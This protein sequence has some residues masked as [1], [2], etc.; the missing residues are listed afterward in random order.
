MQV[1]GANLECDGVE[2][3]R[4]SV[5]TYEDALEAA[6]RARWPEARVTIDT[7]WDASGARRDDEV[8]CDDWRE[9]R[10]ALDELTEIANKT[11]MAWVME[12]GA[13]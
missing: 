13:A 2:I 8:V 10:A 5:G 4:A 7:W 11:W 1:L 6:V 12:G 9:E 3:T